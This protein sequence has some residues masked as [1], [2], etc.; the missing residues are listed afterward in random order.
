MALSF[1]CLLTFF[2]TATLIKESYR[3]ENVVQLE[4][5]YVIIIYIPTS[6]FTKICALVCHEMLIQLYFDV[7]AHGEVQHWFGLTCSDLMLIH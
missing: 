6:N 2:E 3:D 1:I 7:P 4:E 5:L